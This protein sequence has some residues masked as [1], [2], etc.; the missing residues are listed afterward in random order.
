MFT[1]VRF[2]RFR[3]IYDHES[4]CGVRTSVRRDWQP[5]VNTDILQPRSDGEQFR[6]QSIGAESFLL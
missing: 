1:C 5:N 6:M 4:E 2:M 3:S